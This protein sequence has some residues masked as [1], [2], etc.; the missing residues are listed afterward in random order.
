MLYTQNGDRIVT[1]DSMTSFHPMYSG[2]SA[3]E[4]QR[5]RE[6]IER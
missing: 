2:D 6:Q 1:M 4:K 3:S 5:S